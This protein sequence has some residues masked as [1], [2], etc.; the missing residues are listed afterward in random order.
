MA[1]SLLDW[2]RSPEGKRRL[3]EELKAQP[4]VDAQQD[5]ADEIARDIKLEVVP[6]G[7]VLIE[8]SAADSDLFMILRGEFSVEINGQ[9]VARLGAGQNVG[10]MAALTGARRSATVIA[11]A[12]A[13]VARFR[14]G[15]FFALAGRFPELWRRV[16][17]QLDRRLNGGV[18]QNAGQEP[19]AR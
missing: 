12:D 14:K 2:F 17:A 10:E 18:V 7:T 11:I 3:I 8:Q 16:A 9:L 15:E 5:L 19:P 13:V 4:L 1:R 6:R